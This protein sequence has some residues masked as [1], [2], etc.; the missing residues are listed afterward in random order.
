MLI[1]V[2]MGVVNTLHFVYTTHV[3][4]GLGL[5]PMAAGLEFL[6]Q[7]LAAVLGS[8][9]LPPLLN[10]WGARR[11]LPPSS[12]WPRGGGK[13]TPGGTGES[14]RCSSS[15]VPGSVGASPWRAA[16]RIWNAPSGRTHLGVCSAA[17]GADDCVSAHTKS[18]LPFGNKM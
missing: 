13:A 7:G 2:V 5:S 12:R 6:P 18:V 3:Q 9:L 10:R 11:T 1:F 17:D 15:P 14:V 8:A 4:D 16:A